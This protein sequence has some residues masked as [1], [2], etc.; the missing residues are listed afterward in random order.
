[1][2]FG[3]Q[4]DFI[5]S[6][7]C[8]RAHV[9]T[10]GI[11]SNEYLKLLAMHLLLFLLCGAHLTALLVCTIGLSCVGHASQHCLC[12]PWRCLVWGSPH[13]TACVH[14]GVVLCGARL[15]ALLVRTMALSC[16][17]HASQHCLC[18]PWHCLVWGMPHTAC[19][20]VPPHGTT[21][22][23]VFITC[24]VLSGWVSSQMW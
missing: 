17:G 18:T 16:V 11:L 19:T 7:L 6:C 21:V 2:S 15:T 3:R 22:E 13:S 5:H 12:A 4:N 14:H 1:M 9:Y 8:L 10:T 24:T 23:I 20:M